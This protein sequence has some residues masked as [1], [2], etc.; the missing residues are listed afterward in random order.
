[1]DTPQ[2][3]DRDVVVGDVLRSVINRSHNWIVIEVG[4]EFVKIGQ[5]DNPNNDYLYTQSALKDFMTFV[6]RAV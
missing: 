4:I 6:H 2:L 1:M 5:Y 3:I